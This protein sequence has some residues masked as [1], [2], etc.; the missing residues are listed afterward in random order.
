VL[1]LLTSSECGALREVVEAIGGNVL[2]SLGASVWPDDL[3]FVDARC[4]AKPEVKTQI[5][6]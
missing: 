5:A 1:R 6:L 4:V 2:E 3:Y